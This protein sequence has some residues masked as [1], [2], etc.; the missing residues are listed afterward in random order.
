MLSVRRLSP[1]LNDFMAA[2]LG[3]APSTPSTLV[4]VVEA[5]PIVATAPSPSPDVPAESIPIDPVLLALDA[6]RLPPPPDYSPCQSSPPSSRMGSV[7]PEGDDPA[8]SPGDDGG[9]GGSGGGSGPGGGS[10]AG[11][12]QRLYASDSNPHFGLIEGVGRGHES[13]SK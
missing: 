4:P 5:T 6:E 8:G 10:G 9:D 11:Q 3:V 2:D 13:L 7:N 12:G 1:F